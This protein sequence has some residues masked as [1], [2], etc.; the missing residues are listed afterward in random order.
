MSRLLSR[1]PRSLLLLGLVGLLLAL[2]GQALADAAA[3]RIRAT[4]GGGHSEWDAKVKLILLAN[5]DLDGSGWLDKLPEIQ[6]IPCD[7]WGAMNEGVQSGWAADLRQIYGFEAGFSWV[8]GVLG[9]AEA[10]RPQADAVL[11]AC[12]TAG[13]RD[14]GSVAGS[15]RSLGLLGGSDE[16]DRAVKQLLVGAYDTDRSGAI[17]GTAEVMAMPCDVFVALDEGVRQKWP[18][19]LRQV[20][21]FKSGLTWI[22]GALGFGEAIRSGADVKAAGCLQGGATTAPAPT[23]APPPVTVPTTGPTHERI[24]AV[25]AGG[26]S[27]WDTAVRSILMGAYDGDG[28]GWLDTSAEVRGVTCEDWSAMDDGVKAGWGYGI[29]TIYGF[30]PDY[31][32][33]G[34]AVGFSESLRTVADGRIVECLQAPPAPTLTDPAALIASFPNGGTSEWDE[35]VKEVLVA[36]FDADGSGMID[37]KKE[38]KKIGCPVWGAIDAGVKQRFPY[39]VRPVY[40][41]PGGEFVWNGTALGFDQ[42][43]REAG[44]KALVDCG[45]AE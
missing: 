34:D 9:F 31:E 29:R 16:W 28:S 36:F 19:G 10:L 44:D 21:G 4:P 1:S 8:G 20:Y 22:G 18:A 43:V 41:F 7:T 45:Y 33:V 37:T 40:G 24:R 38:L 25:P 39:G 26:S 11:A 12:Q 5:Y 27:S 6:S 2:A 13:F 30:H 14:G 17:D 3:D 32:W 15:I 23:P 35:R 42:K